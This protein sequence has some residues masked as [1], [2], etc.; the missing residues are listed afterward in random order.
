MPF[1]QAMV[2]L[3][4]RSA[5][6]QAPP[7]RNCQGVTTSGP[8]QSL[9]AA[10]VGPAPKLPT[11]K[12]PQLVRGFSQQGS[13]SC[14]IESELRRRSQPFPWG[15]PAHSALDQQVSWGAQGTGWGCVLQSSRALV[16]ATHCLGP[17]LE[18]TGN[19]FPIPASET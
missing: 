2:P 12:K 7:T 16:R 3:S 9:V 19:L 11:A 5:L 17:A 14:E 4:H 15:P 13:G 6:L 18:V 8:A 10:A 1:H